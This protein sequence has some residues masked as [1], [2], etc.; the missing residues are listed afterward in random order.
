MFNGE[1]RAVMR[2]L[3][4]GA[5][6]F[7]GSH[8]VELLLSQG[9][10][11]RILARASSDVSVLPP[12]IETVRGDLGQAR[13]AL[14]GVDAVV[15]LAGTGGGVH[16]RSDPDAGGLRSVNVEGTRQVFQAARDA[17]VR[18]GVLVTSMWT[19]LRPDLAA[20]SPYV[21]SRMD[22]EAAALEVS[23]GKLET[24]ILCPAF[25]AGARDRGPNLPGALILAAMRGRMPIV[26]AGGMNWIA[27]TDVA[28]AITAALEQGVPGQR[29][30]VGAE[31]REH[32]EFF[33]RIVRRTQRRRP[34]WTVPRSLLKAIAA[35]ADVTL[36]VAA[37][38]APIA[39]R[40]AVDLLSI[41]APL[42]CTPTWRALGEPGGSVDEAVDEAMAWFAVQHGL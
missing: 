1:G 33:A 19:M 17:G 11:V 16:A 32:A 29:Y 24:V 28:L 2:V 10:E 7:I 31:H 21:A 8:V 22:S 34:V 36:A 9:H 5:T 26:P 3:V 39:L 20:T 40:H 4:T 6:G 15:H 18:R 38:R 25:V 23:G 13:P 35:A 27:A 42:D 41:D 37:K 12:G 30:L 14:E